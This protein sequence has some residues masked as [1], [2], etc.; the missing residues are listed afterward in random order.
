MQHT[1]LEEVGLLA[2]SFPLALAIL[3]CRAESFLIAGP[4]LSSLAARLLEIGKEEDG[5]RERCARKR[6]D[7]DD[8]VIE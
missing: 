8:R 2:G 6:A 5:E 3:T 7:E 1:F 4:S